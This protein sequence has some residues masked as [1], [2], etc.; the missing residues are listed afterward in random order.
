MKFY[1]LGTLIRAIN[2]A[3]ADRHANAADVDSAAINLVSVGQYASGLVVCS[4]GAADGSPTSQSVTVTLEESDDNVTYTAVVGADVVVLDA[5][6]EIDTIDFFPNQ[7]KQY[8]RLNT[9]VALA[10]G[11]SPTIEASSL[12]LLGHGRN[13]PG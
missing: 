8:I 1:H 11:S 9:V 4:C 2:A 10:A 3:P 7:L 6:N 13:I 5:N 12:V